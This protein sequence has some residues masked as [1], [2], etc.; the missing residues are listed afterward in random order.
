M[1]KLV[2]EKQGSYDRLQFVTEPDPVPKANE[3]LINVRAAGVNYADTLVRMGVYESAKVYVGWPITPGFEVSGVVGAVG[4]AVKNFKVGDEVLAITRF[5][6]YSTKL[7]VP[8]NQVAKLPHGFKLEESAGFPAVFMTAYHS[9]CQIVWLPPNSKVLVHS[10]AGGVGTAL[11]QVAKALDYTVVGIVGAS[12][13]VDYVKKLGA[14]LVI[15]KSSEKN[16]WKR[17]A[18]FSPE[19]FDAVFDANGF[20]TYKQSYDVLRPTGKLIAYGSHSLLPKTGGRLNYV[21]AILGLAKT[22]RFSP[23]K[24]IS[25]NKTVVGFNVSFLFERQDLIESG[26][27][28]LY[29]L[30]EA[31]KLKPIASTYFPFKQAA[32]AHRLIESGQSVG[33]IILRM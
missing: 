31:G 7:V 1:E 24:L 4:A 10:A 11:V 14:D 29:K 5:N 23:L 19:G 27:T 30:A 26:M 32:D 9:L 21:Q 18:E 17:V 15:D 20:T 12:H 22:P 6:G 16:F 25:D 8:E 13:K 2:I 28:A 3:V 33:K